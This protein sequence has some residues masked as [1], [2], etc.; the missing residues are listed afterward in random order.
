MTREHKLALILGFALVLVVGV[1]ISDHLS[2]ARQ[3]TLESILDDSVAEAPLLAPGKPIPSIADAE[4]AADEVYASNQ[5]RPEQPMIAEP[6]QQVALADRGD[7]DAMPPASLITGQP[8]DEELTLADSSDRAGGTLSPEEL[9][10]YA[11]EQFGIE[12]TPVQ[13]QVLGNVTEAPRR[14]ASPGTRPQTTQQTAPVY[15]APKTHTVQKDETLWSI[16]QRHYG[17]G[18]LH[19]RLAAYN[20]SR[21]PDPSA[22]RVGLTLLIPAKEEL[23][24]SSD[25]TLAERGAR[26]DAS[27]PAE[28]E[29]AAPTHREYVV[30]KGDTLGEISME[31]LGTSKRWREIYELNTDRIDDPD[32][33]LA[34]TRLRI[35]S[36]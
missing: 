16:A 31:T 29:P 19:A 18:A 3:A 28:S 1:L 22:L 20:R 34:G 13:P 26:A 21:L 9:R 12:L 33:V 24:R 17:D 36:S 7:A 10:R 6:E 5:T 4:R 15:P 14:D 11:R 25:A 35:P 23:T 2:G 8:V 32:N 30:Q 27:A